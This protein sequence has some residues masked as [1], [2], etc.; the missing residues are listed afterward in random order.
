MLVISVFVLF[1]HPIGL[2]YQDVF[3]IFWQ[4]SS[5]FFSK[6]LA[7]CFIRVTAKGAGRVLATNLPAPCIVG[8]LSKQILYSPE[9]FPFPLP[10]N[11]FVR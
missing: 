9:E 4:H 5:A 1:G 11:F 10:N 6:V 3:F 7:Y 2:G 8:S